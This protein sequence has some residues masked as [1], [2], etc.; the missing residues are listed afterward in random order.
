MGCWFATAV[1]SIRHRAQRTPRR[2]RP[3]HRRTVVLF[4]TRPARAIETVVVQDGFSG[5]AMPL[6][7]R[8]RILRQ[9]SFAR[10][11]R[12]KHRAY[13]GQR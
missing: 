5:Q 8:A 3:L 2:P 9:A 13:L 11:R 4:Q 7:E 1:H 12:S 10:W 6:E